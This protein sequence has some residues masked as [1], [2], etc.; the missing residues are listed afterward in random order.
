MRVVLDIS[1]FVSMVL[2][3]YVG[4]INDIWKAGRFTLILSDAI[5][6]EYLDV[7][8]RPKLHLTNE[9][10]SVVMARLHR[11]AEFVTPTEPVHAIV[12]DS[13]DN[14]FLEA[15]LQGKANYVVSGDNHLL[16]LKTFRRIPILTAREFIEQMET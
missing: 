3:G 5:L 13:A 14:K 16:E 1:V 8:S 4:K 9:T 10:V 15:A 2:G 7:L 6:S 12:S 11:Q